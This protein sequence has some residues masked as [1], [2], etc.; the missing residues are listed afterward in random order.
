[1]RLALG[2]R[3][4]PSSLFPMR[5]KKKEEQPYLP[6]EKK[7]PMVRGRCF[8]KN[9]SRARGKGKNPAYPEGEERREEKKTLTD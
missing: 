4:K 6:G 5:E 1:L 3:A 9:V 7:G 2:K 8:G